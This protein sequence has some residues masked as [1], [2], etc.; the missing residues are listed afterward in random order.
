MMQIR[1]DEKRVELLHN[2]S[3]F[4]ILVAGRRWGKTWLSL[5]WLLS[6]KFTTNDIRFFVAPTYRQ[7]KLIAW[8][9]LKQMLSDT[10]CQ[11]NE[12]ELKAIL[13]NNNEIR[14]VGADRANLLR[15]VGLTKVVLD[16]FAYMKPE[17]WQMVILPMLSTTRGRA[18]FTGTPSGYN[19]FHS[20]FLRAMNDPDWAVYEYKTRDGGCVDPDEIALAEKEMDERTFRQEFEA[21]FE[22]Y[23]GT[24][25]YNFDP[26]QVVKSTV[27]RDERSPLW[28]TCDFNKSPMI[29]LVCQEVDGHIIVIDEMVMKYNAKTQHLI[30]EFCKKYDHV[31]EKMIYVTGDASSKYETH[32]DFTSD[33]VLIRDELINN[34]WHVILKVP[35]KNPN[36][37]NRVNVICSLIQHKRISI[38]DKAQYLISDL[39][40]NETDGKGAKSKVDPMRTHASDAF[41]YISWILFADKFYTTQ[42]NHQMIGG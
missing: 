20:L 16:E 40:S 38:T 32:R 6:G 36:I 30:R 2:N 29:W 3:R 39:Q 27:T 41:D 22:T 23:E 17:V 10:K 13:P 21:T 19:H 42:K 8:N 5:T 28:L 24:L 4:V 1:V 33:Y 9:V 25:Y 15:G 11:F 26:V 35:R 37:N 14:I 12:T 34:N 18:L 31:K 7:G